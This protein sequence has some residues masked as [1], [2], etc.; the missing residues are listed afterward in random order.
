[1]C[2]ENRQAQANISFSR[3]KMNER[4]EE[5]SR[6]LHSQLKEKIKFFVASP[7]LLT[8]ALM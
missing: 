5:L 1:M 6:D 4:V 2:P 8:R 7:L 3:S